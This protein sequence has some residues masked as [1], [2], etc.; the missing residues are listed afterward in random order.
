MDFIGVGRGFLNAGRV[1]N[2]DDPVPI[3]QSVGQVA[4][5]NK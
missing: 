4:A 5:G 3:H 1:G 2:V